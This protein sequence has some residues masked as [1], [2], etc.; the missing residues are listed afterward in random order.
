MEPTKV[1][2]VG[3]G[4][5]GLSAG[6]YLH[7]RGIQVTILESRNRIGGRTHTELLN[8]VPIDLGASWM[9]DVF[10]HPLLDEALHM[11]LRINLQG[12]S[13]NRTLHG[14]KSRNF[15]TNI[16]ETLKQKNI[17]L[18]DH[19]HK[20]DIPIED[21]SVSQVLEEAQVLLN[22]QLK[23]TPDESL[24]LK[25]TWGQLENYENASLED[26][27]FLEYRRTEEIQYHGFMTDGYSALVSKIATEVSSCLHLKTRVSDIFYQTNDPK[28]PVR[29]LTT[30]GVE[31]LADH[32]IVTVPLGVLKNGD[33]HFHPV[34]PSEKRLSIDRMGFGQAGKM[35][36]SFPTMFWPARSSWLGHVPEN[37]E[38]LSSKI[39]SFQNLYP[40]HNKPVLCAFLR[41]DVSRSFEL[42]S[43]EE[44]LEVVL[45]ALRN[46]FS[47]VPKP[48]GFRLTRWGSDVNSRGSYS[49]FKKGSSLKDSENLAAPLG[50]LGFAGEA[51]AEVIGTVNSAVLSGL[52]EAKRILATAKL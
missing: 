31:Y 26:L 51:T 5:S 45:D 17:T 20:R 19:I 28:S 39:N 30:T 50:R 14:S 21:V 1:I 18:T 48:S 44:A 6:R 4:I 36:I 22:E 29:V 49:Y 23:L 37:D 33:I 43:D 13:Y 16:S 2:I 3:A 27:S 11:N 46:M 41:S 34:L 8:D 38:S 35:F 24:L 15:D 40:I 9:H 12:G 47:Y 10:K 25:W 42:M 52:R 32:V 7:E